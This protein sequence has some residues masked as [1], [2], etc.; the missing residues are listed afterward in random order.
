MGLQKLNKF[1]EHYL[2]FIADLTGMLIDLTPEMALLGIILDRYPLC[3]RTI[4]T[5][6]LVA[7]RLTI[8]SIWKSTETPNLSRAVARI[9]TQAQYELLLAQKK[10]LR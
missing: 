6:T 7:A 4:V 10:L 3:F 5:H 8:T 1:W 2:L 9:N